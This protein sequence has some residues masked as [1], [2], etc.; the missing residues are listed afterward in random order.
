MTGSPA[1]FDLGLAARAR[2]IVD[3]AMAMLEEMG[4]PALTMRPLADRLGM[5]AP[6]IY[7]H[8]ANR[9]QIKAA[10]VAEGLIEMGQLLHAVVD[11]GGSVRDVLS[12]YRAAGLRSPNL[13]RLTTF[14]SLDRATLPDGLEEWSGTPFYLVTGDEHLAQALWS[15]AHGMLT[16]ELDGRYPPGSHL[17]RTWEI[18]AARFTP[19]GA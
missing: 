13:Y 18:G 10:L 7:K 11:T 17:D 14:G 1:P 15:F 8:F 3:A 19:A 2:Q 4:W 5:R 6:S 9:D 16:L 12:A